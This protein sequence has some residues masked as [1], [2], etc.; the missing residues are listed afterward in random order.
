MPWPP[1][2]C[3]ALPRAGRLS[4]SR[5]RRAAPCSRRAAVPA[6]AAID[7]AK[8]MSSSRR[9]ER[10]ERHLVETQSPQAALARRSEIVRVRRCVYAIAGRPHAPAFGGAHHRMRISVRVGD[11]LLDGWGR[12][13]PRVDQTPS[14]RRRRV[15]SPRTRACYSRRR[16]PRTR[17]CRCASSARCS[18]GC[19]R[20]CRESPGS[21][22]HRGAS[23]TSLW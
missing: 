9:M 17:R 23:G 11:E 2:R 22:R 10:V 7:T 13:R 8:D 18:V 4:H 20:P 16:A 3:R 5:C 12:R 19:R 6:A 15:P 14:T 1:R 21:P